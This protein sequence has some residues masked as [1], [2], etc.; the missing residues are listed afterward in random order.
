MLEI[1]FNY[2]II[3]IINQILIVYLCLYNSYLFQN[4][5]N[6]NKK[7]KQNML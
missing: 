6:N 1:L 7:T 5:L 3:L 2:Y 4:V